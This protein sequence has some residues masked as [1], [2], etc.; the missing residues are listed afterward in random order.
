[1]P[2]QAAK[3]HDIADFIREDKFKELT[4]S[5]KGTYIAVT[6]PVEDTTV[7]VVIKPG[8]PKPLMRMEPR[9][10]KAMFCT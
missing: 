6:V 1:M 9:G 4:M 5:S 10:K 2:A 8:D 3:P 7:F